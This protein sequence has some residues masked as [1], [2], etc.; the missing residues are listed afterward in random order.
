[1]P[2]QFATTPMEGR[3]FLCIFLAIDFPTL[4]T[5]ALMPFRTSGEDLG[6][7]FEGK[8]LVFLARRPSPRRASPGR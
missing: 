5:G 7:K 3:S 4:K 1:V 6:G 8:P 2:F